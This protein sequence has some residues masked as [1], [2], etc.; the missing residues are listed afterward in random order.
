MTLIEAIRSGKEMKR[1]HWEAQGRGSFAALQPPYQWSLAEHI[2]HIS[3][4]ED[5]LADDWILKPENE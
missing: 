5:I 2:F 3:T 1:P 4:P